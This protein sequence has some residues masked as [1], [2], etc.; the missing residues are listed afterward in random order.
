M[1]QQDELI[2]VLESATKGDKAAFASLIE[3][4]S[5]QIHAYFC[6]HV[7]NAQDVEDLL[8]DYW[9]KVWKGRKTYRFDLGAW[10]WLA[11]IAVNVL[12]D[13]FRKTDL[14]SSCFDERSLA[15][16]PP[17][18]GVDM[19]K[20]T[21]ECLRHLPPKQRLVFYLCGVRGMTPRDAALFAKMNRSTLR[22][23]L[24]QA[25]KSLRA[26]VTRCFPEYVKRR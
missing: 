1:P 8:Q 12:R 13:H 6:A 21:A 17:E 9:L 14:R 15:Q 26:L 4:A 5:D 3:Q 25:R 10:R 19:E 18:I 24:N 23:H 7:K 11:A 16:M 22:N 2:D 20:V